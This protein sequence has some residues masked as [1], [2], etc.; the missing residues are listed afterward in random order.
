MRL[1][2]K[3]DLKRWSVDLALSSWLSSEFLR[4][5]PHLQGRASG[6]RE[7]VDHELVETFTARHRLQGGAAMQIGRKT[8]DEFATISAAQRSFRA[9]VNG[10]DD[11]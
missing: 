10:S 5:S 2:L 1:Y 8:H 4:L 11:D 7:G 3:R 9:D 6:V